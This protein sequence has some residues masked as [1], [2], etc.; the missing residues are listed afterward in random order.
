MEKIILDSAI[1]FGAGRYR[2]EKGLLEECGRNP[3]QLSILAGEG[4]VDSKLLHHEP[5]IL[6]WG[7]LSRRFS[8]PGLRPGAPAGI[9]AEP[10]PGAAKL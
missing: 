4:G 10:V 6:L 9:P 5:G 2:Q 7:G 1:K 3:D 8:G